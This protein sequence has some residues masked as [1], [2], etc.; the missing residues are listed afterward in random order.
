MAPCGASWGGAALR[1]VGATDRYPEQLTFQRSKSEWSGRVFSTGAHPLKLL[2]KHRC[3]TDNPVVR[4]IAQ[5]GHERI[6]GN[7]VRS[8][9]RHKQHTWVGIGAE[10]IGR[11]SGNY[12]SQKMKPA[13][14]NRFMKKQTRDRVVP[15][16]SASVS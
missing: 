11:R 13:L 12:W 6:L 4:V 5:V 7:E 15:T 2:A 10:T 1:F 9:A 3:F 14:L 8:D 16:I